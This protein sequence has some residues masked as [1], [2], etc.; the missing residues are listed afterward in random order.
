MV[1][2]REARA[3]D[4]VGRE[5]VCRGSFHDTILSSVLLAA[6]PGLEVAAV[7]V[8]PLNKSDLVVIGTNSQHISDPDCP[9]SQ[10]N[11]F[12]THKV[13]PLAAK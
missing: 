2:C 7:E 4:I 1:G 9:D 10:R 5:C 8:V 11:P 6:S 13:K 3:L 12:L